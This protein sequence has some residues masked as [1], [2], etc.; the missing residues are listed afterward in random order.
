LEYDLAV[1]LGKP[2]YVFLTADGFPTDPHE[3]EDEERTRLQAEHRL[4]LI[5]TGQ[6]YSRAATRV[7][8]R[9]FQNI[10]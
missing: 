5:G 7:S 2:V 8:N 6:D 10:I 3:P 9:Q 1:E 4:R